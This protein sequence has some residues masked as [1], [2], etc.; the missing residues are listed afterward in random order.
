VDTISKGTR[1]IHL[2]YENLYPEGIG[3]ARDGDLYISSLT[4]GE[5]I[6]INRK[7]QRQSVFT[8]D[9]ADLMSI[10]GIHVTTDDKTVLAC[11]A[12]PAGRHAG[13]GSEIV[14]FNRSTGRVI[15]R[16]KLPGG[17]L[18]N[19]IAQLHDRTI[20]L[21]DSMSPRILALKSGTKAEGLS[22]WVR[23]GEFAGEGFNLNGIAVSGDLVFVNKFNSGQLFVINSVG[24]H[25]KVTEITL[26]RPLKGPDGLVALSKT[27]LLVI[28]GGAGALTRVRL[29]GTQGQLETLAT[30]L[31]APTTLAVYG[32]DA[33][34]VQGQLDHFFG[35]DPAKPEPFTLRKIPLQ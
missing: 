23:S 7:T 5:I 19:D 25:R 35:M 24:S 27:E 21:T 20:L 33:F 31:D 4:R 14:V 30:G 6:H 26:N 17:G 32:P 16:H 15:G 9:D 28:E 12:D 2:P 29:T 10:L 22:E 8:H 13:R 1:D 18:C 34:V 11:S 3:V